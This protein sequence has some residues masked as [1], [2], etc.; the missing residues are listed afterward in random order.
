M[1]KEKVFEVLS[2]KEMLCVRGG[3]E[4]AKKPVK[5]PIAADPKPRRRDKLE[6]DDE[7]GGWIPQG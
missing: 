6:Y 7:E 3:T 2:E 1:K 5:I 4:P